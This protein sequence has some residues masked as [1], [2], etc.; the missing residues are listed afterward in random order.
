MTDL[1]EQVSGK[2]AKW[3]FT[4]LIDIS[5][6]QHVEVYSDHEDNYFYQ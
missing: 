5:N 2:P 3:F 4:K 6:G 1:F